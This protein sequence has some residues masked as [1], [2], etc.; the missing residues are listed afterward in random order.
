M[1]FG[2]SSVFG[3]S[4]IADW[5]SITIT[6]EADT[7][8]SISGGLQWDTADYLHG[9]PFQF[10][11]PVRTWP[12]PKNLGN[13]PPPPSNVP[14]TPP[15]NRQPECGAQGSDPT[16]NAWCANPINAGT[17]NKFEAEADFVGATITGLE[18]VRYYNSQ[19]ATSAG[20]G[21]G[22]HSAWHR[23]LHPLSSDTVSVTRA[24]GRAERFT[25]KA[26]VWQADPDVTSRPTTIISAGKQTGWQLVGADDT[27]ETYSLAGELLSITN[28]AGLTTA[29]TYDA[30]GFLTAVTGPFGDKLSFVNDTIGRV[31][32][33]TVPDGGTYHY[34]YD[35][36]NNLVSVTHPDGSVRKTAA[37]A[38]MSTATLRSRTR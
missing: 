30:N 7:G 25:L 2:D 10:G 36:N 8:S 33:M 19:D 32:T 21:T 24:D 16:P 35:A 31:Q 29:L 11:I 26:G 20:C 17:G 9:T 23:S 1:I 13:P 12:D 6:P 28:R 37:S 22:W 27:I 14:P 4:P 38:N 5:A 15:R 18:L 3:P 34:A